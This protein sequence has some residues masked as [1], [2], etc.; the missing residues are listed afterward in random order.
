MS[1]SCLFVTL[2]SVG[3]LAG[4]AAAADLGKIDRTIVKEPAYK[5]K[6]AYCFLVFGPEAKTRSWL[7]LDGDLI[8]ID[9][10]GN[11]D[12]TERGEKVVWKGIASRTM[13]L[14]SI[15]SADGTSRYAVSLRKFPGS[16]RLTVADEGRQRY[17]VGDPDSDPLVFADRPADAPV[18]HIGGP[19]TIDLSYY[20]RLCLRVRVGTAGLGKGTFAALVL[21]DVTPIAEVE[22]PSKPGGP[23]TVVKAA[24]KDR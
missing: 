3:Y 18:V 22:F 19:L 13:D 14:G 1:V 2:L 6:P 16:V 24:L 5:G 11:G 7:V 20:D 4:P 12:L 17:M 21:P 8:Y 9:R 10:N 15:H 23:P